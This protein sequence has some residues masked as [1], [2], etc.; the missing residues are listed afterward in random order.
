MSIAQQSQKINSLPKRPWVSI[1]GSWVCIFWIFWLLSASAEFVVLSWE[2]GGWDKI[3]SHI[4][5]SDYL[6]VLEYP[7]INN[8]DKPLGA[9]VVASKTGKTYRLPWCGVRKASTKGKSDSTNSQV[10]V[11]SSSE[12]AEKAG[13]RPSKNCY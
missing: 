10:L 7:S 9:P 2:S 5:A 8:P 1:L 4:M 3:S 6:A 13:Y 12:E 11:F